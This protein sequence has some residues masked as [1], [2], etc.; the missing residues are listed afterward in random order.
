MSEEKED[1]KP[2]ITNENILGDTSGDIQRVSLVS[3]SPSVRSIVRVAVVVLLLLAVKDFLGALLS[4]LTYLFFMIVLAIFLAYIINPLVDLIQRPFVQRSYG[5]MMSRSLA[6]ALSFVILFSILGMS[7]YYLA[8]RVAEQTKTFVA[9][10]PAYTTSIQTNINDLNRRLANMRVSEGVQTQVNEKINTFLEDAGTFIT[11]FL[12]VS[13]VYILTYLPWLILV[14][15]LAFFF[16]KDAH[17][18]RV[19]VLRVVPVGE[20]RTR[21]DSVISDVND[22]LTA[23]ARAQIISCVLIGVICTIGF[24]L[25]GNDYALLLGI[26]AGL[27]EL[28]P[29]LGPLTIAVLAISVAGLESGWQALWTG[30]FL[31]ALRVAQDYVFYP[32][33]VREGIHLH[34]L[35]IILSVLAGEQVAGIPGVFIAIPVVA[36]LTVLYK[37]ILDHT[38]SRGL[39]TGLLEPKENKETTSI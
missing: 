13:A 32:R 26:L 35:A 10:V 11:T 21:I 19:G 7:A 30:V 1:E 18:F 24:Y 12:G 20:W 3:T 23:Y 16:L 6:I 28:I 5:R 15:I 14:P 27:L 38:D 17:L 9:N 29:L 34:P 2:E 37:H 33:I 39:F 8:P 4:S 36:L 31:G 22:T 25:L